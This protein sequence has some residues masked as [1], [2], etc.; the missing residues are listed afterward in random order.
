MSLDEEAVIGAQGAE[1][2]PPT[3]TPD[4]P[5]LHKL[6]WLLS[7]RKVW[8]AIVAVSATLIAASN[9]SITYEKASELITAQV[10]ALIAA[11][12]IED[13]GRLQGA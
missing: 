1:P 2:Y 4:T 9:G 5:I 11:I 6:K 3:V 10:V 12:S 7:S 8:I 13:N